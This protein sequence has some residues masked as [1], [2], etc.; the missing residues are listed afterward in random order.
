MRIV[1][2][3]LI[4]GLTAFQSL[5]QSPLALVKKDG[6]YGFLNT[7]GKLVVPI[8]FEDAY[9]FHDA[10]A[11]VKLDGKWGYINLTGKTVIPHQFEEAVWF[12][13]GLGAVKKGDF[14][15]FIDKTGK[16]V[17]PF[18]YDYAFAYSEG[19]AAVVKG[20][21]SGY[22]DKS[23]NTVIP[24]IYSDA[25][26]FYKG[27]GPVTDTSGHIKFIDKTHKEI[28]KPYLNQLIIKKAKYLTYYGRNEKIGIKNKNGKVLTEPKYDALSGFKYGKAFYK[29][30]DSK[31]GL[32]NKCGRVI[33]NPMYDDAGGFNEKLAPV[34]IN[35]F[36]GYIHHRKGFQIPPKFIQ[37][38]SFN[39]KM[40]PVANEDG[41][42]G[43]INKEGKL[44][45]G[46]QYEEHSDM[47]FHD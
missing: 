5:G 31:Y 39:N 21:C 46:Y 16:T 37:A 8:Q 10:L 17:I 19:L 3:I 24:F 27:I 13:E 35:G 34:K 33:F 44:V 41:L 18:E 32:V 4:V 22:I 36:W 20:E 15:G 38:G 1:L 30:D 23:G 45:V 43:F 6:K 11:P 12:W 2:L 47:G 14:W 28:E 26:D 25:Y 9:S 29:I 40:A 7:D 42:W